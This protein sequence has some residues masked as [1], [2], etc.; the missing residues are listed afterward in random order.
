MYNQFLQSL[1]FLSWTYVYVYR[2]ENR[3]PRDRVTIIKTIRW[4]TAAEY[5][6]IINPFGISLHPSRK[7]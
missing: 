6:Y 3:F 5:I 1:S 7:W 2:K 4:F